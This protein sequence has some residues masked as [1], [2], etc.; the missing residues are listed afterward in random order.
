M[1]C[2]IAQASDKCKGISVVVFNSQGKVKP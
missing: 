2:L 1:L